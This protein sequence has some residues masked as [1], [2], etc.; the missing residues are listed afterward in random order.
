MKHYLKWKKK[1]DKVYV[2]YDQITLII[3][4]DYASWIINESETTIL[5][6]TALGLGL[7]F[8]R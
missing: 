1:I 8:G 3:S 2:N 5:A 6:K 7:Q 4:F